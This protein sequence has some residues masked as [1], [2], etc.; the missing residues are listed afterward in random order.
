L[1]IYAMVNVQPARAIVGL[2]AIIAVKP[3]SA[4]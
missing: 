4:E 3:T 1:N 2:T